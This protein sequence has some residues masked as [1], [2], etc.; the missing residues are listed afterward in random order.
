MDDLLRDRLRTQI[1]E[2]AA[3]LFSDNGIKIIDYNNASA[4]EVGG[5]SRMILDPNILYEHTP[6]FPIKNTW[7]TPLSIFGGINGSYNNY[8]NNPD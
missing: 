5:L 8:K 6:F 3:K 1:N 7:F 4:A 2:K